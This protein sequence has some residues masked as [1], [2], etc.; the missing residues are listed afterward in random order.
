MAQ[1]VQRD[2]SVFAQLRLTATAAY[3]HI[4]RERDDSEFARSVIPRI[5]AEYQA[6]RHLFF[7]TILEYANERRAALENEFGLPLL[8][9]GEPVE[10]ERDKGIRM[11]ALISFEPTPGTVAYAGYGSSYAELS[12]LE[13][14]FRRT[15]DGFFVKLAYQFRR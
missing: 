1:V 11:D 2:P 6:T 12:P 9:N 15:N 3:A 10:A 14:R 8:L 7:R 5:K 13:R 4:N